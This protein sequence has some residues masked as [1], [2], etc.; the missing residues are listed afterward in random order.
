MIEDYSLTL[1]CMKNTAV[2]WFGKENQ[3]SL[4]LHSRIMLDLLCGVFRG[5]K[6]C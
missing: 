2:R 1:G 4:I 3:A 5:V 6:V